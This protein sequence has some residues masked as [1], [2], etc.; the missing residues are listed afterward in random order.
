MITI[1]S[2]ND[3]E[4]LKQIQNKKNILI[5]FMMNGCTWCEKTQSKWNNACKKAILSSDDAIV[6]LEANFVD[7]FNHSIK[8]RNLNVDVQGFPTIMVIKG[9][10]SFEPKQDIHTVVKMFQ[11]KTKRKSKTKKN[12]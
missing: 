5:R 4:K 11:R 1:H 2:E 6:E 7:H 12:L 10:R 3:V 8:H 9:G